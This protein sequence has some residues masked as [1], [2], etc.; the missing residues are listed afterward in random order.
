MIVEIRHSSS[1]SVKAKC[2]SNP[3]TT[4]SLV[5][6]CHVRQNSKPKFRVLSTCHSVSHTRFRETR[7]RV[8]TL[9]RGNYPRQDGGRKKNRDANTTQAS[10][11]HMAPVNLDPTNITDPENTRKQSTLLICS[12]PRASPRV[13]PR[14][15]GS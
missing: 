1:H 9:R 7:F 3:R 11:H 14:L 4:S 12:I 6:A 2:Q 8:K 10:K 5:D 13:P 15:R